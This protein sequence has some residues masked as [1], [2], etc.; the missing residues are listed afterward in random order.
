MSSIGIYCKLA[1]SSDFDI[2]FEQ[3]EEM[4]KYLNGNPHQLTDRINFDEL[5]KKYRSW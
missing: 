1:L 2:T 5:V 4:I 3:M